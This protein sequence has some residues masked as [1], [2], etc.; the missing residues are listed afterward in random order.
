MHNFPNTQFIGRTKTGIAAIWNEWGE[1]PTWTFPLAGND[2]LEAAVMPNATRAVLATER[3]I[4]TDPEA[5]LWAPAVR[6]LKGAL[7]VT[8]RGTV[9]RSN[10]GST[11]QTVHEYWHAAR[12]YPL[13]ITLPG[14]TLE[15]TVLGDV[16]SEGVV[17]AR[18]DNALSYVLAPVQLQQ[19]D[20]HQFN[21]R[22][23]DN[24]L[25]AD[26]ALNDQ[27]LL[28]GFDSEITVTFP[29]LDNLVVAFR[30]QKP[31]A[32]IT[33]K[34]IYC[35]TDSV[36]PLGMQLFVDRQ[37]EMMRGIYRQVGIRVKDVPLVQAT[38]PAEWFSE[39]EG[40]N[41]PYQ[42]LNA[43]RTQDLLDVIEAV[44]AAGQEIRVGFIGFAVSSV[45]ENEP[46]FQVSGIAN[47]V[48]P[49]ASACIVS[50][51]AVGIAQLSTTAHEVGHVLGMFHTTEHDP[52]HGHWLMTTDWVPLWVNTYT[53]SKRFEWIPLAKFIPLSPFYVPLH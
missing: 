10:D 36:M 3:L 21:G 2:T 26:D 20:D 34:P 14:L 53:A 42:Y 18:G 19:I 51:D 47:G 28:A 23:G 16:S 33:L 4:L 50:L 43:A 15:V 31:V 45:R 22:A 44:P 7:H 40:A 46:E 38:F 32:E 27:T 12:I 30:A 24:S 9:F 1:D 49:G 6:R 41:G 48:G 35:S 13:E 39:A 8:E 17:L 37:I 29:E 5:I 52:N 11:V 25:T